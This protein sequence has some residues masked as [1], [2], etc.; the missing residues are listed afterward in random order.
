M[1]QK[2]YIFVSIVFTLEYFNFNI[3]IFDREIGLW[4]PFQFLWSLKSG[5]F[6]AH[7]QNL[8]TNTFIKSLY[9]KTTKK[10]LE[11]LRRFIFKKISRHVSIDLIT[12]I[13]LDSIG[14]LDTKSFTCSTFSKILI[15]WP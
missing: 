3:L 12:T 11:M 8:Q 6:K 2:T 7:L 10:S 1:F 9:P 14:L 13:A 5:C 15:G 4:K